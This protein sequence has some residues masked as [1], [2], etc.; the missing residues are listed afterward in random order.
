LAASG[1]RQVLV[2]VDVGTSSTRVRLIAPDG[3]EIDAATC[4]TR[5][6]TDAPGLAEL[7]ADALWDDFVRL[8]R[9]LMREGLAVR[10]VG[11][12]AQLG[13]ML[14]DRK[15]QPAMPAILWAD[16]R[17]QAEAE[18]LAGRFAAESLQIAGRR[19]TPEMLA[20]RLAWLARHRPDGLARTVKVVSLKDFLVFR[21]TGRLL[22]DETHAS[23]SGLFDVDRRCWSEAL[24]AGFGVD[25]ALL[26]VV[27]AA[28]ERAGEV[29][30]KAAEATGLPVGTPV[31]VGCPDGT[32][33]TVGAG[34][35]RPGVTID[36]AGTTDTILHTVA[37]PIRDP[38][39]ALI[40]NA[41]AVPGLWTAGGPTGL[42]GGAVAWITQLLGLADHAD[43]K[44]A[45]ALATI[46]PGAGGLA[47]RG[48]LTG[49][50]F[51]D[52]KSTERGAI[53]GLDLS[54]GPLHVVRAALE[55]AAFTV[56]A[57]LDVYRR[58]G[59]A[60]EEVVVVGGLAASRPALQLRADCLRVPVVRL[61][62]Q[63]ASSV[64][65]AMLA[66]VSSGVFRDLDKAAAV[67]VS[68]AERIEPVPSAAPALEAAY[69]KWRSS[70]DRGAGARG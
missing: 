70:G 47:F 52:W 35:V 24:V 28:P 32:A 53:A 41:H 67:M 44:L 55:G 15:G 12:T 30:A 34:A 63:E 69:A 2:A 50:R 27:A 65:I 60:V 40:V 61:D 33:G 31:A 26:P 5:V 49:S 17:A 37:R 9:G 36:V 58:C 20:P 46:P 3:A 4:P 11:V 22:T 62:K 16:T 14:L 23:Y 10:G 8:T 18:E 19:I 21:L 25:P 29:T 38:E 66:G 56:A 7:D 45:E 1:T 13:T 57:G 6:V 68:R 51:P 42:T 64:G 48:A 39:G 54:H 59:C 43:E